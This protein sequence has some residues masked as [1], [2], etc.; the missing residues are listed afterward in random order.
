VC[1]A[2]GACARAPL[3]VARELLEQH[4][5]VARPKIAS[6]LSIASAC[7]RGAAIR[8]FGSWSRP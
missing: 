5:D 2:P 1:R 3:E 8:R 7:G 4:A 6:E